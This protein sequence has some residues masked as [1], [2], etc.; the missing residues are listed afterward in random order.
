MEE[1]KEIEYRRHWHLDKRVN[2]SHILGTILIAGSLFTYANSIDKRVTV[3]ETN[4]V[5]SQNIQKE[6][7]SELKGINDKLERFL[8]ELYSIRIED[9]RIKQELKGKK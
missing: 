5:F 8:A 4:A 2:V 6:I 7:K 3:L 1:E 9:A